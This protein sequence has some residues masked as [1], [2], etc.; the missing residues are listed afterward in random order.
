MRHH[1]QRPLMFLFYI[2]NYN[3]QHSFEVEIENQTL[4]CKISGEHQVQTLRSVGHLRPGWTFEPRPK[5][6]MRGLLR[7]T[8][9]GCRPSDTSPKK[10]SAV[11]VQ[12]NVNCLG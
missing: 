11:G 4:N 3:S 7:Q 1:T 6:Q 8:Q 2:F 9:N 5:W 10:T 12:C